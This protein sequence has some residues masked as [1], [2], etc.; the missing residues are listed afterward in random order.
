M[1]KKL[2]FNVDVSILRL[3]IKGL[4]KQ[5]YYRAGCPYSPL[6]IKSALSVVLLCIPIAGTSGILEEKGRK[7]FY[8]KSLSI[9]STISCASCHQQKFGFSDPQQLSKGISGK[10]QFN[11]M[12]L[13]NNF[14][15]IER[16]FWNGRSP[17]LAHQVLQPIQDSTEMGLT[18]NKLEQRTGLSAS[19]VSNALEAFVL[20][21]RAP[22]IPP[23]NAAA[24]RGRDVFFSP[25]NRGGGGCAR[26]HTTE[27]GDR[28]FTAPKM[29]QNGLFN[30]QS[31][32]PSLVGVSLTA[33]YMRDGRFTNLVQ[34]VNHY[35]SFNKRGRGLPKKINL[36]ANKKQDLVAFLISLNNAKAIMHESL[37]NPGQ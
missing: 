24:I 30:T 22:A 2:L 16:Q 26:C 14:S 34:V 10:T 13:V 7:L 4:I 3:H 25:P 20:S 11:S 1:K 32:V 27:R 15:G 18:L 31:K 5:L 8:D 12:S 28:Y 36:S 37:S 23:K 9:N 33:P 17:N 19:D 21:I 6:T 35:A 29:T